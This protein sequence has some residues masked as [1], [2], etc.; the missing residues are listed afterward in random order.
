MMSQNVTHL[1]QVTIIQSYIIEKHKKFQND[2]IILY[3]L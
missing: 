1:S 3:I 2:N